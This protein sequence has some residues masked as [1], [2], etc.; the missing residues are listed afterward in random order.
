MDIKD[1]LYTYIAEDRSGSLR[2]DAIYQQAR[3]IRNDMQQKLV[4]ELTKKQRRMF[5]D[6]MEQENYLSGLEQRRIFREALSLHHSI[7]SAPPIS[8]ANPPDRTRG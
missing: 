3:Q 5:H 4:E 8:P 1:Y 7:Y 2:N 6:Y